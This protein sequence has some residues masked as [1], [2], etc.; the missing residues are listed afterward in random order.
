MIKLT[1][2]RDQNQSTYIT[3]E[4]AVNDPSLLNV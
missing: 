4:T 2:N 1:E 3:R